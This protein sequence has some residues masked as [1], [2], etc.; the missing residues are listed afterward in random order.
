MLEPSNA[1]VDVE[2]NNS[3]ITSFPYTSTEFYGTNINLEAK[4][5]LAWDYF[6]YDFK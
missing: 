1:E 3:V 4:S 2:I 5:N 6:L